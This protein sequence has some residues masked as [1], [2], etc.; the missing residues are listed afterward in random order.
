MEVVNLL[1]GGNCHHHPPVLANP[2]P[3]LESWDQSSFKRKVNP[4]GGV[5]GCPGTAFPILGQNAEPPGGGGWVVRGLQG[6]GKFLRPFVWEWVP[7][8]RSVKRSLSWAVPANMTCKKPQN[9]PAIQ[10]SKRIKNDPKIHEATRGGGKLQ[11][12]TKYSKSRVP[13]IICVILAPLHLRCLVS[14]VSVV[15]RSDLK[16]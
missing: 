15:S 14:L 13:Q 11:R 3:Q 7:P 2:P 12:T 9:L 8:P 6:P 16:W 5:S 10:G 1:M 4:R